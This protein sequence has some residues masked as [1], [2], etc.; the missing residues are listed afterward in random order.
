[1]PELSPAPI[2]ELSE[3]TVRDQ[4]ADKL[5]KGLLVLTAVGI[6][7]SLMRSLTTG[8]QPLYAV[9]GATAVVVLLIA[10]YRRHLSTNV[11]AALACALPLAVGLPALY[12]LGFYGAGIAWIIASCI[13]TTMFFKGRIGAI[14]IVLELLLLTGLALAYVN[15]ALLLSID[16]NDFIRQP[17]AWIAVI[18]ATGI[19]TAALSYGMSVYSASHEAL[20][21]TIRA[22]HALIVHQAAH[23]GL[24]GLFMPHLARDR[25]SHAIAQ[26]RRDKGR[27]ALLYIDLDG[28]KSVN[29][30]H[31]HDAGDFVLTT[32]AQR[33][34]DAIRAVDSASRQ[35]GDEFMVVLGSISS[36]EDAAA[37]A[38]KLVQAI[39][40]PMDYKGQTL[41]IGASIGI[42]VFPDH[43]D[44]TETIMKLAD[45]AM[46]QVKKSG[47]N[48]YAVTS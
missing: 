6:P 13:S 47:K 24:T 33:M 7:I 17:Q 43:A 18:G 4:L 10:L 44:S 31:G 22:Q 25:L 8:W 29:D 19:V 21:D 20:M 9:H 30:T 2:L 37:V 11:K 38:S 23:D 15:H 12:A 26:A 28:F 40:C 35:G 42:A 34:R 39:A 5:W 3:N 41:Q 36:V 46:Y 16:T 1:M 45:S 14:V 27:A 32:V 48:S